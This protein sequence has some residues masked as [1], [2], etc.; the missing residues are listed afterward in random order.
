MTTLR[1]H[2]GYALLLML[3]VLMGLGGV[4]VAS[5]TEGA[6]QET[7]RERY[8]HNQRVLREAKQALLQ[9][10]Y[11]YPQFFNEGPGRLPCPDNDE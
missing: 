3:L 5:F 10:A 6:R 11:N 2:D 9:Y 1:G 7:E 4:V 8:L